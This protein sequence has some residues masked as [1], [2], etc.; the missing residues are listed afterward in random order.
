VDAGGAAGADLDLG[1]DRNLPGRPGHL[2][3]RRAGVARDRQLLPWHRAALDLDIDR[4]GVAVAVAVPND[5]ITQGHAETEPAEDASE[6]GFPGRLT[7]GAAVRVAVRDRES[8]SV[9]RQ[10]GATLGGVFDPTLGGV[11]HRV[12]AWC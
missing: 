5:E 8:G 3:V 1:V 4:S 7:G 12:P 11:E 10:F 6:L 9:R 2:R